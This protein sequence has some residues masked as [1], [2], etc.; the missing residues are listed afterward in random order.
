MGGVYL[1]S[2]VSTQGV[3]VYGR[4]CPLTIRWPYTNSF[5][6]YIKEI[7]NSVGKIFL[8]VSFQSLT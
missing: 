6:H 8:L 2:N 5:A 7:A 4:R 1:V 3:I